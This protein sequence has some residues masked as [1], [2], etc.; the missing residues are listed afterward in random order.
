MLSGGLS[1]G[2]RTFLGAHGSRGHRDHPAAQGQYNVLEND[3]L[4]LS[5]PVTKSA[6]WAFGSAR[7]IDLSLA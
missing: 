5:L 2:A 1:C 3:F 7:Q 4:Y 6:H